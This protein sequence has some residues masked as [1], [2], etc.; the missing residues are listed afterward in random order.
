[1]L[2]NAL[3]RL[4]LGTAKGVHHGNAKL[5]ALLLPHDGDCVEAAEVRAKTDGTCCA[6]LALSH[7]CK[8]SLGLETAMTMA[9][10][11]MCD[12]QD[13]PQQ[14]CRGKLQLKQPN[15]LMLG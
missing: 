13:R 8:N 1:M 3:A 6:M 2:D 9:G 14:G 15:L 10:F 4:V 7:V 12:C 5:V 11:M